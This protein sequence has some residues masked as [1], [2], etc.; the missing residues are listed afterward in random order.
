MHV[1]LK[2]VRG[3]RQQRKR[4]SKKCPISLSPSPI[5]ILVRFLEVTESVIPIEKLPSS[6]LIL[7]FVE[8]RTDTADVEV[9]LAE[10]AAM[11]DVVPKA[12]NLSVKS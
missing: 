10:V 1:L 6:D 11:S 3:H 12:M 7:D 8:L 2:M 4:K 5:T 9:A